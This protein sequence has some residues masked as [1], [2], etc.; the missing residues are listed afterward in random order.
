MGSRAPGLSSSATCTSACRPTWYRPTYAICR[1]CPRPS[2]ARWIAPAWPRMAPERLGATMDF[3]LTAEQRSL[4]R[5][6]AEAGERLNDGLPER[7]RTGGFHL[8][9]WRLAAAAGLHGLPLPR[10]YGGGGADVL[11]TALGLEAF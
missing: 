10:E 2:R 11:T 8:E 1:N 4:C 6:L 9:A 7:E 3:N 5:A